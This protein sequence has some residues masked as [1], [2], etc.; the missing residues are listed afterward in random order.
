MTELDV[1]RNIINATDK[2]MARLFEQRMDAVRMV[3][4]YKKE[5]GLPIDDLEREAAI[6]ARNSELVECDD[7]RS[8]YVDFLRSTIDI[9]KKFQHNL[10]DDKK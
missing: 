6:I 9:S 3:A 10:L 5:H 4:S 7:Y 8:Y 1:A 2:E